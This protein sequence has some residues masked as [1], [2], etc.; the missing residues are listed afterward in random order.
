MASP[1][2]IKQML[3]A[4]DTL[5]KGANPYQVLGNLLRQR[6]MLCEL[7]FSTV[8][9]TRLEPRVREILDSNYSLLVHDEQDPLTRLTLRVHTA[10]SVP[11]T[12]VELD[13]STYIDRSGNAP[14]FLLKSGRLRRTNEDLLEL[15]PRKVVEVLRH[16]YGIPSNFFTEAR[17]D[18][19]EI[20]LEY[21]GAGALTLSHVWDV[22]FN[23]PYWLRND[24]ARPGKNSKFE[25]T[26]H[27]DLEDVIRHCTAANRRSSRFALL[28]ELRSEYREFV[29]ASHKRLQQLNAPSP[30]N[31]IV[32]PVQKRRVHI[33]DPVDNV[34]ATMNAG[35]Q[36]LSLPAT[37]ATRITTQL[38][39]EAHS[40]AN[41]TATGELTRLQMAIQRS[42]DTFQ[43]LRQHGTSRSRINGRNGVELSKS[44]A[45]KPEGLFSILVFRN[46]LFRSPYLLSD[47]VPN[48]D[49]RV[50]FQSDEDFFAHLES[51]ANYH[52]DMS[53][54]EFF[55]NKFGMGSFP[56]SG[57]SVDSARTLWRA[58]EGLKE[59]WSD[60][61]VDRHPLTFEE[62]C[63]LMSTIRVEYNVQGFGALSQYL[64]VADMC[65]IGLVTMP[66]VDEMAVK[67]HSLGKGGIM[68]LQDL[69]YIPHSIAKPSRD[70]VVRAFRSFWE[71]I[72]NN[73]SIEEKTEMVWNT[74]AAEHTLC[75]VHRLGRH[76]FK[77][78]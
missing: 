59:K 41:N 40:L 51:L 35:P 7:H 46:I 20:L 9:S 58:T 67:I 50:L 38:L 47:T 56:I 42:P 65:E 54:G 5:R 39:R 33:I 78:I 64:T 23:M 45:A 3:D 19:L 18:F 68:G 71:Q 57:R 8:L 12:S 11:R 62:A 52:P 2:D 49:R 60:H 55:C 17:A 25:K 34:E 16:W 14:K 21:L 75:K 13:S 36:P 31:T 61:A 37:H 69:G 30:Q 1:N 66:T 43:P 48:E 6:V 74:V 53:A 63:T 44:F 26:F 32:G 24:V 29:G 73:L 27:Q 10:L 72:E 22:Y 28:C 70:E 76:L 77:N 15:V 4:I